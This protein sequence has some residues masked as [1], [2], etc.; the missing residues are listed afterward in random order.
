MF[1]SA[2]D[3]AVVIN[4]DS[5]TGLVN[6]LF[7]QQIVIHYSLLHLSLGSGIPVCLES[8]NTVPGGHRIRRAPVSHPEQVYGS[9]AR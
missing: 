6:G 9:R 4:T 1:A 8:P 7:E 3:C 2:C 5:I